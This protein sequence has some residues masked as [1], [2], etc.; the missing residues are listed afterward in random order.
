[1][2]TARKTYKQSPHTNYIWTITGT[3]GT[4]AYTINHYQLLG[5]PAA[6]ETSITSPMAAGLELYTHRTRNDTPTI[7]RE[8]G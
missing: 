7:W 8:Q 3:H 4:H 5:R 2:S 1:M 6:Q